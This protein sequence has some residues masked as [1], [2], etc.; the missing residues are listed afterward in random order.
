MI[1]KESN[2]NYRYETIIITKSRIDKGLL[3]IPKSLSNYFPDFNSNLKIYLDDSTDFEFKRFS[4]SVSK[5]RESRIGG[6]ADWFRNVNIR[7]GDEI[8]IQIIDKNNYVY[9]LISEKMFIDRID[10][11]QKTFDISENEMDILDKIDEIAKWTRTE[12]SKVYLNEYIRLS[13]EIPINERKSNVKSESRIKEAT[14]G[15]IRILMEKLYKGHCQVCNFSFLK[16]NKKPYYEIHHINPL[17]GHHPQNLVLVCANCHRQFEFARVEKFFNQ[18][19][20]LI[21][22]K[23]NEIYHDVDNILVDK[24][25]KFIKNVHDI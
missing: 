24:K 10:Q 11:I 6:L 22:V 20:W 5:T 3:A 8:V 16:R 19:G 7:D 15:N 14:P 25:L 23:F 9:R 12:K 18:T 13:N 4:S 1:R 2:I 21:R 17:K